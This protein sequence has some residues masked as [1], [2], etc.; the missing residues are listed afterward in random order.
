MFPGLGLSRPLRMLPSGQQSLFGDPNARWYVD[1]SKGL[2]VYPAADYE[3][4]VGYNLTFQL[5]RYVTYSRVALMP[6]IRTYL[7][8]P[9]EIVRTA[10]VACG[11]FVFSLGGFCCSAMMFFNVGNLAQFLPKE[12][13]IGLTG[14]AAGSL[15][16]A[17][18]AIRHQL[19]LR[20]SLEGIMADFGPT[21]IFSDPS[22]C[23]AVF[24]QTR[25]GWASRY[26]ARLVC[27]KAG[28]GPAYEQFLSDKRAS[29]IAASLEAKLAA[30]PFVTVGRADIVA[31][32]AEQ[33]LATPQAYEAAD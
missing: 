25:A 15:I 27:H 16:F 32:A 7:G 1:P 17:G 24:D 2:L 13:E 6:D 28:A 31:T 18:Q 14:L 8:R 19:R 20:S 33:S 10:P 11:Y 30:Q 9:L 3:V 26:V 29:E 5:T 21:N 22:L 23:N 4:N 12:R